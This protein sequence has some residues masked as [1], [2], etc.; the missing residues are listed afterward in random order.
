MGINDFKW[1]SQ[2]EPIETDEK[3]D[4]VTDSHS[5]LGRWKKYFSQLLNYMGK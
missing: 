1:G 4:L 3:S 2:L 5:I